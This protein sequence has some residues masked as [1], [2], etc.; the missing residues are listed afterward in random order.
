MA[1]Y[2]ETSVEKIV[3][4]LLSGSDIE[5]VDVEYVKERDWYLRVFVDKPGGMGSED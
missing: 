1:G 5:L 4:D 2:V 3:S